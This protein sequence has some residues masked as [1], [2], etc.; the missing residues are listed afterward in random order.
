MADIFEIVG[1]VSLEGL[2]KAEKDLKGFGNEGK[3][4]ASKLSALGKVAGTVGK[5]LLIGT[6]AVVTGAIGLVKQV[7]SSYG[8]LQ[9]SI[10]GI[11]TLFGESAQKVIENA[12]NA[13]TTAGISANEYMQQVTSFSASLLQSL[14]G[15]TQKACDSAD[16][17]I[18]DMA[19][20]S[21]KMGT[22]MEMIINA[23]QGFSRQNYV[24]LDNLK[25]GYGGTKTE[26][27]RLLADASKISGIQYD[28]SNLNDVYSAIHV[29]Q[30]ELGI[31]GTTAL[32]AGETIEGSF[33]SL[34]ASWEN[35]LAGLGNPDADMAQIVDNLAK[36][37]S[38]AINNVIPVINNMVSVLPTVMDSIIGAINNLAP[39]FIETFTTIVTQVIN[40]VVNLLPTLIPMIIDTL[41]TVLNAIIS[42]FPLIID[43]VI[44]LAT[45]L[46]NSLTS[47]LPTLVSGIEQVFLSLVDALPSLIEGICAILPTLIPVLVNAVTNMIMAIVNNFSN[48]I[49]PLLEAVPDILGAIAQAIVANA[50]ALLVGIFQLFS[51]LMTVQ[52]KLV[53]A[54]IGSIPQIIVGI[55]NG[56][57]EGIPKLS[58]AVESLCFSMFDY[59]VYFFGFFWD[60]IKSWIDLIVETVKA[61][62]PKIKTFV[63]TA[64]K[65]AL[66][67]LVEWVASVIETVK[68]EVP[69]IIEKVIE[70]FS[71]L[72]SKIWNCF[73]DVVTKVIEWRNQMILKAVEIG[74]SFV[75]KIVTTLKELPSKV[76][77]VGKSVVEGLWNGITGA[78]DWLKEKISG[79]ADGVINGFKSAFG[80]NSPAKKMYPVGKFIDEGVAVGLEESEASKYAI[81]DTFN[82]IIK[83]VDNLSLPDIKVKRSIDNIVG[84]NPMQ[85]Y[86]VAFDTQF[87]T[88]NDGFD[89]LIGLVGQ[90]LP[91]IVAGMDRSIVL[92]GNS[93]VVGMSRK[94]D[95]QLGKISTSKGRGNV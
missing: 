94:M 63:S 91:N 48:I 72:P 55:V 27:E 45:E 18:R 56:I 25:L 67:K 36:G 16:M 90:Y 40:A 23:Y 39:T 15:D 64:F 75:K 10:G 79:F 14:G 13:Y 70:F 74:L 57:V 4:S 81:D 88:L 82:S 73:V 54:I 76:I 51:E 52:G 80:I 69:K 7:S 11:E 53:F 44:L 66:T 26:M 95:L 47:I 8:Q 21:N 61:I 83:S 37:L 6:G 24:M 71:E 59:C 35:F 77:G 19:D 46:L 3:V 34:S 87:S 9:Q 5:G 49:N 58:Q 17:A 89:R 85:T 62:F 38:G 32:E 68:T 33:N 78:G 92:D 1:K 31:T 41:N 65:N 29:I 2:D 12:N 50:P 43:A 60:I 84:E 93:L 20:N 86:K 42:N 22:S 28:I 30:Q